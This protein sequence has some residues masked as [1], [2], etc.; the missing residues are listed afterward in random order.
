M[1]A[2]GFRFFL[3]QACRRSVVLAATIIC[4]LA[5]HAAAQTS[6]SVTGINSKLGVTEIAPNLVVFSSPHGNVI[7]TVGQDGAL[8]VGTPST[9]STSAISSIL[10]SRTKASFRYVVVA[11]QAPGQLRGDGGWGRLG[12]FV[13][14]QEKALQRMGGN[15]MGA[16]VPLPPE[17]V[18]MGVDRPRIAFS[19]VL[20][21]DL[22]GEAIHIIHQKPGFSDADTITHFHLAD[23][24]YLGDV[25]P[26]DGYP[27]IDPAIGG[28]LDGLLKTLDNWTD[29]KFRVVPVYGEVT[30]GETVKAFHDMIVTVRDRVQGMIKEGKTEAQ[31]IAAHPTAD[32]DPRWGNGRTR[33][34]QFVREL[35]RELKRRATE[36]GAGL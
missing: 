23:L 12:A 11:E 5:S 21:F 34:D 13:A 7:A 32:F 19:D 30:T 26:G 10:R 18:K 14:M 6:G 24:V 20:S 3:G 2:Y 16:P 22:N 4:L 8:L 25:F 9:L 33:P 1:S 31:V 36:L 28:R 35:Y 29:V 15:K 17:F 27:R